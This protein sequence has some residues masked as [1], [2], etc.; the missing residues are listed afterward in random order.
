MKRLFIGALSAFLV[1]GCAPKEQEPVLALGVDLEAFD[2]NVRPQDD[3]YLY[4]NGTWL[5]STEIPA[6]KATY[7][8]FGILRDLSEERVNAIIEEAANARDKVAGSDLQRVGDFY[9]SYMNEARIA[10]LGLTPLAEELQRID[11]IRNRDDLVRYFGYNQS[12]GVSDPFLLFTNLDYKDTTKYTVY[13][14]HAGLGLPDRDYYFDDEFAEKREKYVAFVQRI[15]DLGGISDSADK[16]QMIMDLETRL[17]EAHWTRIENRQREKTYNPF[18]VADA[19][20]LT[21]GLDWNLFLEGADLLDQGQIVLRQPS[22]FTALGEIVQDV[23]VRNWRTYFRYNLLRS[24]ADY[25][26]EDFVAADFDFYGKTL[27][28]TEEIRP[29]WK[30]AVATADGLIGEALG[31]IYV[32]RHFRPE[33]KVRMDE[34]IEN[35][36][37]A[38]EIAI[39]E[40]EWMGDET[41]VE[42]QAKLAKFVTKIGYPN[43]WRDYTGLSIEADDLVGNVIRGTRFEYDRNMKQLRGPVDRDEWFMTPQTINAYYNSTMNEIVFPAAILQAPFFN[44]EADDATNYGAIGAVIGHEFSHGFDD[45]GRKTDGNGLLRDWWSE[46]D[47]EKFKERSGALV[48][49][50]DAFS[51]VEGMNVQGELTLGENIGDLAGLTMAYKAYKLSLGDKEAPV[52]D[53]Y[54]G[55]QRFF[56]GW[57]QVWRRLYREDELKRR[58]RTDPHSPSQYRVNGIVRNMPEWYAAFGASEGDALYLPPEERVKIW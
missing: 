29:R 22:Y 55:D 9:L 45:Q 28:G 52:I 56:L 2:H 30:R 37:R 23:S 53:G 31:R 18:A 40:L 32:D 27:R 39:N 26:T 38:F 14:H 34:M 35:L 49:Q 4:V 10:E 25:L 17:A 44:V 41:K 8:A 46:Q 54:T 19:N 57:A 5:A 21:P 3:F 24:Y 42:A 58:L 43:K 1:I 47:A 13:L 11:D 36:R 33:S 20:E 7:G 48:A 15:L 16:A 12:I 50:Y 6:D 51:P